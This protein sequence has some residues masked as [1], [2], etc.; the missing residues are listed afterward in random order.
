M[1]D[2]TKKNEKISL[3]ALLDP[4]LIFHIYQTESGSFKNVS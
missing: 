3:T 1:S 4:T 2:L